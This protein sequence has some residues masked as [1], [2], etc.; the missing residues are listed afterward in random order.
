M[1]EILP[2]YIEKPIQQKLESCRAEIK[3]D[4]QNLFSEQFLDEFRKTLFY[5]SCK[6][7][8]TQRPS[9]NQLNDESSY[10][11]NYYNWEDSYSYEYTSPVWGQW[12]EWSKCPQTCSQTLNCGLQERFRY[13]CEH[14]TPGC[15][16]K[17]K[18][19][20]LCQ[21]EECTLATNVND[22]QNDNV[23]DSASRSRSVQLSIS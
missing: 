12:L 10:L 1:I 6:P 15:T 16:E 2:K 5:D 21:C 19:E 13:K 3:N 7:L 4:N 18:Q 20:K 22:D 23:H 8:L 17:E 9:Q 14:D 11:S